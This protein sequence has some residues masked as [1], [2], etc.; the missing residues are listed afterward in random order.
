MERFRDVNGVRGIGLAILD[1]G[2]GVK[3]NFVAPPPAG[4]VPDD[5]DGVPVIVDVV[6]P[7]RPL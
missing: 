7:A 5:V 6:G 3:V 2:Y 4:L 1:D